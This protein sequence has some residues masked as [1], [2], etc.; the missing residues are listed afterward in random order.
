MTVEKFD[1]VD[2][3]IGFEEGSIDEPSIVEGFQHMINSGVVWGLQGM[4]GRTATN[5][6]EEGICKPAN[7]WTPQKAKEYF[8]KHFESN[9]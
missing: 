2:F 5:L 9:H 7:E 4:Y 3:V 1:I 8:K 6:I